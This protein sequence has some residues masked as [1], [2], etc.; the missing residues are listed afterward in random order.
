M[1]D[2]I[3]YTRIPW[4]PR[5]CVIP[6]LRQTTVDLLTTQSEKR[7]TSSRRRGT[8]I[9]LQGGGRVGGTGSSTA[10]LHGGHWNEIRDR[11][12]GT[13]RAPWNHVCWANTNNT[14]R[15]VWN[16]ASSAESDS[17][18]ECLCVDC[19]SLCGPCLSYIL[20]LSTASS[21]RIL[22]KKFVLL[23]YLI[24]TEKWNVTD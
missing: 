21:S 12:L 14:L 16:A 24:T 1:L 20:L 9:L 13:P 18:I 4:G 10:R 23:A 17:S 8:R 5:S 7:G 6:G 22:P 11:S 19:V 2:I 15:G 3:W